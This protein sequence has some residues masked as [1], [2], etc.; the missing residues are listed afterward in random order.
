VDGRARIK[1]A[2]NR[3]PLARAEFDCGEVSSDQPMERMILVLSPDPSRQVELEEL[4]QA[5]QDP[6]SPL[7]HRWIAPD[8]YGRRFGISDSDLDQIA[9][10]LTSEGFRVEEVP[11]GRR[12]IVF[13]GT[14]GQVASTFHT[15]IHHYYSAGH[16]HRANA[17]DP[18]IP[19]ALA[20]L[21]AGIASLHD[22]HSSP[23]LSAIMPAADPDFT[24]GTAHYV[25]PAD[26]ATIYDVAPLYAGGIDGTG[27]S[28]AVV[29]R[30]NVRL[31]DLQSF[32]SMV[33]LPANSPTVILNG[34]NPGVIAGGEQVE[35][36]LDAEW[37]GA[38]AKR[39][40]VKFVVS[41]STGASD[42]VALSAQYIVNHNLAP[43]MTTSFSLCEAT[44]GVAYAQFWNG[45]WQQAAAQGITSL[46]ASGDSG[47]AG[48]DPASASTASNGP[49]VNVICSTP[50]SVCIGG[51]ELND[52]AAPNLYWLASNNGTT[53]GSAV[54]FRKL[55]G[56][57]VARSRAG[58][59]CG[60]E[61][62]GRARSSLIPHGN[63]PMAFRS[64]RGGMFPTSPRP[65]PRTTVISCT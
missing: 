58:R 43:V 53:L 26:F 44:A 13:S 56:T 54:I 64:I 4:L 14:V 49:S 25:A 1:L 33:G 17:A 27:T 28:I 29:A 12:S 19:E 42:G 47:A 35:A 62:G 61:A 6:A 10:W 3:H 45:L 32:R 59:S 15:S 7:Y 36:T 40:A 37:A 65:A 23:A 60:P 2:G 41:A 52:A 9:A 63:P 34:P 22:F 21:V 51:T 46:V 24:N 31:A 38:V 48:C 30:S 39:A 18:E 20:G 50:Y 5:Q 16:M 55:R 8:E 11:D 57:Q